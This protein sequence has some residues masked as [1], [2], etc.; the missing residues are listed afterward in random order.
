[1]GY[2]CVL[3]EYLSKVLYMCAMYFN[4][5]FK[6]IGGSKALMHSIF[7]FIKHL[8]LYFTYS[9]NYK[10]RRLICN[11]SN[12]TLLDYGTSSGCEGNWTWVGRNICMG[13]LSYTETY[14]VFLVS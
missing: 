12:D 4:Y 14:Y 9:P 5:C 1:V 8:N 3:L 6:V 2:S 11:E 7:V 13:S 10:G